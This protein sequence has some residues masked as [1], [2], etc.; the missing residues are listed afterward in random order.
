MRQQRPAEADC[1]EFYHRYIGLVPDG[2]ITT[3]LADQWRVT[4]SFLEAIPEEK[5][6]FRYAPD[7]WSV[8]E[9]VGHLIDVERTFAFRAL[10]IARGA[11]AGLPSMEQDEWAAVSPAGRR[12]LSRLIREWDAVRA[13][14]IY[15]FRSFGE[16][17]WMRV[18][19]ASDLEF[20]VR[21]FPWIVAGHEL[22]HRALLERDYLGLEG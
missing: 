16:A 22:H 4:E 1:H 7:K 18:G 14:S 12:R 8:R 10:W 17:A 6:T 2:D 5:E 19:M 15:L 21:A 3:T 20:R 9:V 11:T 13:S